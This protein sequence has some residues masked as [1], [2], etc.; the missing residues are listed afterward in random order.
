MEEINKGRDSPFSWDEFSYEDI[1]RPFP[2]ENVFHI[3]KN[4]T[5]GW[6]KESGAKSYLGFIGEGDSFRLGISTLLKYKDRDSVLKPILVKEVQ[7]FLRKTYKAEVVTGIECDDKCVMES[8][9]RKDRFILGIDKDFYSCPINFYNPNQPKRGVVNCNKF[10]K[11]FLDDGKVRG[12]G[13]LHLYYQIASKDSVDNYAANCF[14]DVRWGEKSAYKDLVDCGD[15]GHALQM[16]I[17]IFKHL[18]PE[19]KKI[20]GWRGDEIQIDWLYVLQEMWDMAHMQR[21]EGD[22]VIVKDVLDNMGIH[23]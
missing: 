3:A 4:M 20:I 23:Y 10:G 14:S 13:R 17:D 15:D 8:Y 1:Q 16:L 11:L 5:E 19:P 6:L 2:V 9:K 22:R 12:E 7:E 18:Y 21:W